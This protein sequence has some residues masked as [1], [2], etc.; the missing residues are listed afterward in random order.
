MKLGFVRIGAVI[1]LAAALL[2]GIGKAS[3]QTTAT[4]IDW[5]PVGNAIGVQGK[6]QPD[7]VY[8]V[9]L[10]RT[11][12][13]V[14][15]EGVKLKPSFALGTH[16]EFMSTGGSNALMM[17]D[18]VLTDKEI[19]PVMLKLEQSGIEITALHN[20]LIGTKPAVWYMHVMGSGDAVQ[21]ATA[22]HAALALSKTPLKAAPAKP[23]DSTVP[24]DTAALDAALGATGK[25]DGGV[26]KYSFAPKYT[27][28]EMGMSLPASMGTATAFA[29]QPLDKKKAAITGDFALLAAQV[30]PVIRAL[31]TNRVDVTALH[32][33]MLDAT[34]TQFFMHFFAKG[35]AV[36][37]ARGLR[38]ALNAMG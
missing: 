9:G 26:Y 37:L 16:L 36:T 24:L 35:D 17:G 20:H 14:T 38:A 10:P 4:Q 19:E 1:A 21:L 3:A 6:V 32:S 23:Q 34:P 15:L 2:V 18:L 22:A 25:V 11:D 8:R 31:R 29:F 28:T 7:G 12:L 13:R 5:T 33:H 27:V 30:N